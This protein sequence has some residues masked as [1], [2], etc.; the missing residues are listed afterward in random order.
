MRMLT[1]GE[2]SRSAHEQGLSRDGEGGSEERKGGGGGLKSDGRHLQQVGAEAFGE[3]DQVVLVH[4]GKI[5]AQ[6]A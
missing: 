2:R 1:S 5:Q 6:A 4:C 3:T